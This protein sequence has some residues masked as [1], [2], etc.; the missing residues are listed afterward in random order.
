MI[1][2][3]LQALRDE[4]KTASNERRKAIKEEAEK[5][6]NKACYE[7]HE[8]DRL[9]ETD[10]HFPYCSKECHEAWSKENYID[11]RPKGVRQLPINEIQKKLKQMG[12]ELKRDANGQLRI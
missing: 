4:Y 5:L 3:E 12:K 11:K 8:N 9:P 1:K 6:K 10:D 7:C 2:E